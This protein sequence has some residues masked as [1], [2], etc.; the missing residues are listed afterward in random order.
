MAGAR[1]HFRHRIGL[2]LPGRE[3]QDFVSRWIAKDVVNVS[4]AIQLIKARPAPVGATDKARSEQ[5][6]EFRHLFRSVLPE[7]FDDWREFLCK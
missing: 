6:A 5:H 2:F 1:H 7:I 4:G 3:Q